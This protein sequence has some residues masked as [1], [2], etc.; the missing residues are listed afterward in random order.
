MIVVDSAIQKCSGS[1]CS[2]GVLR[3]SLSMYLAYVNMCRDGAPGGGY[4]DISNA[5]NK[6]RP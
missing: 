6:S 1:S 2:G 5:T 3:G 4:L